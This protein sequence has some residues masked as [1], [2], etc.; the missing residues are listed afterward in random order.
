MSNDNYDR[1]KYLAEKRFRADGA[2]HE[3]ERETP[4]DG[5]NVLKESKLK[6]HCGGPNDRDWRIEINAPVGDVMRV[7]KYL[8]LGN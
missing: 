8:G 4:R 6:V 5:L 7:L 2:L 3:L 1:K